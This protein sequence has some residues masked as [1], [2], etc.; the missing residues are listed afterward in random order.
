MPEK[1][2]TFL[3]PWTVVGAPGRQPPQTG[4]RRP[5]AVPLQP[6][7]KI[8]RGRAC[9][10]VKGT[11]RNH[12]F[13]LRRY[14]S[15]TP[16]S[17]GQTALGVKRHFVKTKCTPAGV[18]RTPSALSAGKS[19]AGAHNG[20]GRSIGRD[21]A[22]RPFRKGMPCKKTQGKKAGPPAQRSVMSTRSSMQWVMVPSSAR[23]GVVAISQRV[24]V[25]SG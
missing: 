20:A 12:A 18:N 17:G 15:P 23:T 7:F 4:R 2:K 11:G 6:E 24:A 21:T 8:R 25:P 1:S 5:P 9:C 22:R 10:A 13:P 3:T 16:V 14:C 19:V